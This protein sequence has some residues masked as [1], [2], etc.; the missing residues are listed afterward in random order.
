MSVQQLLEPSSNSAFLFS[1]NVYSGDRN[2]PIEANTVLTLDKDSGKISNAWGSRKF[3]LPHMITID[4]Q[5]NIWLTDV[6]LH[7]VFKY[8]PYGGKGDALIALGRKVSN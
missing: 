1:N 7:Q 6:A 5:N 2:Q 3:F 8:G 4:A